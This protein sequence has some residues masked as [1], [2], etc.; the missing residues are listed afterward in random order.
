[1]KGFIAKAA[2]TEFLEKVW[3]ASGNKISRMTVRYAGESAGIQ[4]E[5]TRRGLFATIRL[6][7]IDD[8]ADVQ[9]SYFN[10]LT[11]FALHEL[12]HAWFTDNEPWDDAVREHGK[13]LGGIVNALEDCRAE[14]EVIR[15]GY[16]ENARALFTQLCNNVFATR[17]DNTMVENVAAVIAVE[18]RRLNGYDLLVPN[19]FD[20]SPWREEIAHALHDLPSC[21]NTADVVNVAIELW[22]KIRQRKEACMVLH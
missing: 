7:A 15:A 10:D 2:L 18:G 6:P 11:G 14:L 21:K 20:T 1:M 5:R 4:F 17:F 12:G 9:Q 22:Q 19:S 16:T 13:V 3:L 8:A